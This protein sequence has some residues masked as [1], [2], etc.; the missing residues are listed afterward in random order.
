MVITNRNGFKTIATVVEEG[1]CCGCGTCAGICPRDAIEMEIDEIKGIYLPHIDNKRCNSCSICLSSCPGHEVDLPRLSQSLF[2]D[3]DFEHLVGRYL[4]C[5]MGYSIDQSIRYNSS[6]G[7]LVTTFLIY[8]LEQ[9][10][11]NGALITKMSDKR[12]LEP[13]P[14]IARTKDDII[15][16]ACSKY[17]P[18]PANV[19]LKEILRDDGR[20]AVVGVPCHI[21]GIRKAESVNKKLRERII[22]HLGIFCAKSISFHGTEF[23]LKRMNL[24]KDAVEKISYRGA[25]WP[26]NMIIQ[27]R[28]KQK[29]I[30]TFY[31]SYSD[32][33]FNSFVMPRCTL[34]FDWISELA[35]ISFGDAWLPE[36]K[37]NDK[38]GTSIVI[39]RSEQAN[40]VMCMAGEKDYIQIKPVEINEVKRSQHFFAWKKR[41]ISARFALNKIMGRNLP[42]Y[43][44]G[45]VKPN[46]G[47]YLKAII[48][49]SQMYLAS[50]PYLWKLLNLYCTL[51]GIAGKAK[52]RVINKR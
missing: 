9:G 21:H 45:L 34:C 26:G 16:A 36:L 4:N 33:R 18:V 23:L 2:H 13:Q 52:A 41:D 5:Y 19:A 39:A 15:S 17:C 3:T 35:D 30:L 43:H 12:P 14:F 10:L 25:G 20:Y 24:N 7:G 46:P 32:L 38:V 42:D 40:N 44:Q 49:A 48:L 50:K 27:L 11:I 28:D 51:L 22:F 47:S 6:S 8:A 31:P 1:L 29:D 37:A